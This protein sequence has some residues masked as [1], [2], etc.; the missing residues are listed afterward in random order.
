MIGTESESVSLSEF[1]LQEDDAQ[2]LLEQ[3]IEEQTEQRNQSN[4]LVSD[5]QFYFT[6]SN[7]INLLQQ[8]AAN[9]CSLSLKINCE[10]PQA[11][12]V[13]SVNKEKKV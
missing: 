1:F 6:N 10:K 2:E 11:E 8:H 5:K 4:S 12:E 13:D 9:I 7:M 3:R